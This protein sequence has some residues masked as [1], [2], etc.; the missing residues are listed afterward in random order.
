[1]TED[2]IKRDIR[3]VKTD[4]EWLVWIAMHTIDA[5]DDGPAR[6]R[7]ETMAKSLDRLA[8]YAGCTHLNIPPPP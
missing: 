2:E 6:R 8:D 5:V 3:A 7:V 4:F 1:M